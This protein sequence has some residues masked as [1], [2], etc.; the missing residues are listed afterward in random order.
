MTGE[1]ETFGDRLYRLPAAHLEGANLTDKLYI[2][3]KSG[4]NPSTYVLKLT[5][6]TQKSMM[7]ST[8][9]SDMGELKQG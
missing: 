7:L 5:A 9:I 4:H 3:V 1:F 2:K 8:D 6:A